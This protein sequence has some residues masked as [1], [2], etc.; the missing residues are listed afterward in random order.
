[1]CVLCFACTNVE[2]TKYLTYNNCPVVWEWLWPNVFV[3]ARVCVCVVLTR[4]PETHVRCA[5]TRSCT[6]MVTHGERH[7]LSTYAYTCGDS[8]VYAE[9]WRESGMWRPSQPA[10]RCCCGDV[11]LWELCVRVRKETIH[12]ALHWTHTHAYTRVRVWLQVTS[13][14]YSF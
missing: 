13:E 12:A 8:Y 4:R 11:K 1:M 10:P 3:S 2:A 9:A 7:I 6:H 14:C 5:H